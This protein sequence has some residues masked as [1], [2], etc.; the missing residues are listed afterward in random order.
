MLR[1]SS[2]IQPNA[3]RDILRNGKPVW[4]IYPHGFSSIFPA[5]QRLLFSL[6]SR[7]FSFQVNFVVLSR[8]FFRCS[9][10]ICCFERSFLNENFQFRCWSN[11]KLFNFKRDIKIVTD[12]VEILW[13]SYDLRKIFNI[14][15]FI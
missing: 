5:V 12:R 13:K 3:G 6:C 15:K 11:Q 7:A 8:E 1:T 2:I 4:N 9:L 14:W 10:E